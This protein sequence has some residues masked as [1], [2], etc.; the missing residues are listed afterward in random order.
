[1]SSRPKPSTLPAVPSSPSGSCIRVPQH[2]IAAAEAEHAAAPPDMGLEVDIPAR[3]PHG[4]QIG[5]GGFGAGD[6]DQVGIAGNGLAQV[7]KPDGNAGFEAQGI[8]VIKIGNAGQFQNAY[9]VT[10]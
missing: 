3:G 7:Q 9:F 2:L 4:S 1:M 8:E 10:F 5:H 6:D